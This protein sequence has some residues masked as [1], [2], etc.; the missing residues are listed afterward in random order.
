MKAMFVAWFAA[1]A[2]APRPLARRL[3]TLL[4]FPE[5]RGT[6]NRPLGRLQRSGGEAGARA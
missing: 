3:A 4:L 1:M 5:R 2:I 6:L